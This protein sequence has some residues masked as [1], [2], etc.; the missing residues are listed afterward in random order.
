M[1]GS[2][3]IMTGRRFSPVVFLFA[4]HGLFGQNDNPVLA[5]SAL[6]QLSLEELMDV[7]VT[8]VSRH[9]E[10][11]NTAPSAIQVI[12]QEEIR[13]SGALTL[14]DALKLASNLQVAQL[15]GREWAISARGFNHTAANKLLVMIDGRTVYTPLYS[16]VFWESQHVFLEDVERIEVV[17]GPGGTL[18]GSNAVNGVI[19][20]VTKDAEATQGAYVATGGG[21]YDRDFLMARF[22]EKIAPNAFLRVYGQSRDRNPSLLADGKRAKNASGLFQSGFRLDWK[23]P[24][25]DK[26]TLQGDL[27]ESAFGEIATG[28]TE[29]AGQNVL[30]RWTHPFSPESD[31]QL[32]IYFDRAYKEATLGPGFT[33][34]DDMRTYDI[35]LHHRL[36][37]G[38][39]QSLTW[40]LGHRI[41]QDEVGNLVSLAFLPADKDMH[42]FNVFL[43]DEIL[44]LEDLRLTLGS[45]LEHENYSS[46]KDLGLSGWNAQPSAR[47][48]WSPGH[49]QTLWGALSRAVRTPSRID[50]ELYAPMPPVPAIVPHFAG[51]PYFD[52]EELTAYE[53]GYRIQPAEILSLSVAAFYHRYDDLRSTELPYIADTNF[54]VEFRNGLMGDSRGIELSA[55]GQPLPGWTLQA[56]Y[57]YLEKDLWEK[58][59]HTDLTTPRGEWND[60]AFQI[61]FQSLTDLPAGFQLNAAGRYIDD[62]PKPAVQARFTYDAGIT[63]VHRGLSLSVFGRNLADDRD[64]EFA[65]KDR[66]VQE[67]PRSVYGKIAWRL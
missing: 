43:Q 60:P 44:L 61:T 19:N 39:R 4:A 57:T 63:W 11:L 9:A 41:M 58:S 20:I 55:R 36:P 59:G 53:L 38:E 35:E 10:K 40:G 6:K 8:L 21:T 15:D 31:I 56:G 62:L 64:P 16:G 22:G 33:F 47:L 23:A 1:G 37:L 54:T 48:A 52:S 46:R 12:T 24:S 50:V 34:T 17:S 45:K 13:R 67:I 66:A 5:P 26:L 14:P 51:S 27:Y 42:R 28:K 65:V 49:I 32:Q 25:S 3:Q 18:W 29:V 30:G 2:G 7:E